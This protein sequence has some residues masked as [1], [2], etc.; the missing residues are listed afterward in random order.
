MRNMAKRRSID[1]Y[2]RNLRADMR[3]KR[4]FLS[5]EEIA[6]WSGQIC[7]NLQEQSFFEDAKN[8]CFYY[9]LG[10]EANLLPLAERAMELGKRIAFPRVAGSDMA[11]YGVFSLKEF[12]EGAFHVME[13][14]GCDRMCADNALV[15]VPGLVFDSRGGRMGYGKGYYDRFFEK[16]PGCLKVGVCYGMQ[17]IREVPCDRHDIFMDAV[18]TEQG[19]YGDF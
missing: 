4:D 12:S 11:F 18:V 15:L 2:K 7:K 17:F 9:P 5:E 13:P 1:E 8:I 3:Q 19:I 6:G 16:H 14:V 10:N